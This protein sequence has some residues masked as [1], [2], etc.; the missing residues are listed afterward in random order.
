MS[1]LLHITRNSMDCTANYVEDISRHLTIMT[2]PRH[3][4]YRDT[5][6]MFEK[7][8]SSLVRRSL[9]NWLSYLEKFVVS[10]ALLPEV[11]GAPILPKEGYISMKLLH[12]LSD[13]DMFILRPG[14]PLA[15]KNLQNPKLKKTYC[16]LKSLKSLMK[17]ELTSYSLKKVLLLEDFTQQAVRVKDAVELLYAA[18]N[19]PYLK[20][21]FTFSFVTEEGEW[22]IDFPKWEFIIDMNRAPKQDT[23]G[24]ETDAKIDYKAIKLQYRTI[25]LIKV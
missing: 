25:P 3:S 13:D 8:T 5:L 19:H 21:F 18:V 7:V 9:P 17:L 10:D 16:Y 6:V 1:F 4:K 20:E 23:I 2:M 11:L 14:Q 22:K 15:M 12:T 24:E